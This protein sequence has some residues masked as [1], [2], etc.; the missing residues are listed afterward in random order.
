M[1]GIWHCTSGVSVIVRA[2]IRQGRD[3]RRRKDEG[4]DKDPLVR[5]NGATADDP[6][7]RLHPTQ[8]E[9]KDFPSDYHVIISM[10]PVTRARHT[11]CREVKE[12]H[13]IIKVDIDQAD[14]PKLLFKVFGSIVE[15]NMTAQFAQ[16]IQ[17]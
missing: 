8:R 15:H 12:G 11:Y 17:F 4:G 14:I 7:I 2:G 1:V 13:T 9:I 5:G 10:S 16:L 3:G 6:A